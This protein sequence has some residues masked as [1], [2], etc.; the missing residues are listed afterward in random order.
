[1]TAAPALEE[2][3]DAYIRRLVDAA[4]PL[5]PEQFD[6]LAALLRTPHGMSVTRTKRKPTRSGATPQDPAATQTRRPQPPP[7]RRRHPRRPTY[8]WSATVSLNNSPQP[9]LT[10]TA[11]ITNP[12]PAG[13]PTGVAGDP[14][15]I[16]VEVRTWRAIRLRSADHHAEKALQVDLAAAEAK[17][18]NN[19]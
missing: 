2:K 12:Q 17:I 3:H 11:Q 10:R 8:R 15:P 18:T 5:T 16:G 7:R 4:P 19:C 1:M 14:E 6:R 9:T 13:W